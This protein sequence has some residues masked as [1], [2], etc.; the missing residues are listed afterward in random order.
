MVALD[1]I[2][3]TGLLQKSPVLRGFSIYE[4]CAVHHRCIT[5]ATSSLA[6]LARRDR[7]PHSPRAAEESTSS[8]SVSSGQPR[9]PTETCSTSGVG[10]P[11]AASGSPMLRPNAR[12]SSSVRKTLTTTSPPRSLRPAIAWS[13]PEEGPPNVSLQEV[14][15]LSYRSRAASGSASQRRIAMTG[16]LIFRS[17]TTVTLAQGTVVSWGCDVKRPPQD[18]AAPRPDDE[19]LS[20]GPVRATERPG[21]T[22]GASAP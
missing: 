2:R 8:R 6:S 12:W 19:A 20:E 9:R 17:F 1:R 15:A 5:R 7:G 10:R 13:G 14:T 11:T 21:G 3:L 16:S 18:R 22:G 4:L